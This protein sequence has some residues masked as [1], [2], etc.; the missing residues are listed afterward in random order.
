MLELRPSEWQCAMG[1]TAADAVGSRML[2]P[3]DKIR[4]YEYYCTTLLRTL[5]NFIYI[6][7]IHC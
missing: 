7:T 3:K 4:T 2:R 6:I 5:L 1:L